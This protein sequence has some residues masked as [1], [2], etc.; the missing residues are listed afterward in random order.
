MRARHAFTLIELLVVVAIIALLMAILLPALREARERAKTTVCLANQKN[1]VWAFTMY[2]DDN[3]DILPGSMTD[4]PSCWVDWPKR[5][6]GRYLNQNELDTI[7]HL[8]CHKRGIKDGRLYPYILMLEVY[9]CPSDRR[10]DYDPDGGALA[11][12]TYSMPNCMN[13]AADW[14]EYVCGGEVARKITD[15]N[16]PAEKYVFVEESDP[17]GFNINSWVMHLD[18]EEWIDPLTVWHYDRST[19]SFADGHAEPKAWEEEQTINMS[20]QHLFDQPCPDNADW[21]YMARGWNKRYSTV[22]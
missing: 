16:Q 2:A 15:I 11:Y 14:E 1:L 20:R 9:H 5:Q 17:R 21:E 13:G 7:R 19:I 8:A 6:N 4:S 3:S 22:P 12:R 10:E 18:R